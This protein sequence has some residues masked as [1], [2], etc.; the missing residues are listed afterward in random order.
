LVRGR[1]VARRR[2]NPGHV[3]VAIAVSAAI[4]NYIK[5]MLFLG[6]FV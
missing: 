6:F 2:V 4:L 3:D 5:F 1:T